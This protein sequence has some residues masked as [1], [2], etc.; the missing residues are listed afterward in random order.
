MAVVLLT[1]NSNRGQTLAHLIQRAGLDLRLVVVEDP[2]INVSAEKGILPL[3][4]KFLGPTYRWLKARFSLSAEERKA[5][6]FEEECMQKANA[7]VEA[8]IKELGVT[9]RPEGITYLE[10]ASLHEAGVITAV[11]KAEP[12]VCVVLGTSILK[13]RMI[14][15][16]KIGTI[17]AHTSILPEY[18]GARSEFWQCYNQHYDHVGMT[19]HLI[20]NGI[21]TGNI[22]FQ[23]K[24]DV[25]S[26]P[27]PFELRA[28]NTLATLQ[29]YVQVLQSVLDGT[30]KPTQQ[31][32]CTTP[33][34]RFK[35]ITEERRVKLYKRILAANA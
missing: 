21:D 12:D 24:Q 1:N 33:T 22:L 14:S 4:K 30:A 32:N 8:Y 15:I 2:S 10:A 34:Y 6:R 28:N 7:R 3:A 18:R 35:D 23:K 13:D 27:E 9:G 29:N 11:T 19:I 17:N 25:G 26:N 20:D 16:P 31:G 5:L